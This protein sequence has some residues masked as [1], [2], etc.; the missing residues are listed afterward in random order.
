MSA[1]GSSGKTAK[2][3]AVPSPEKPSPLPPKKNKALVLLSSLPNE[4]A[5][6]TDSEDDSDVNETLHDA[7][8]ISD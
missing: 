7:E 4:S 2:V 3:S 8:T 6:V 1:S 5:L